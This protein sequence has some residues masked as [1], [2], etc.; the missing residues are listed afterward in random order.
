ME[1]ASIIGVDL[2]KHMFQIHGACGDGSNRQM[3]AAVFHSR[4]PPAPPLPQLDPL[5][6]VSV[7]GPEE[8]MR[9][10]LR[11]LTEHSGDPLS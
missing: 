3:A 1:K 4:S 6:S 9:V 7:D 10:A 2:A 11:S 8:G 5:P